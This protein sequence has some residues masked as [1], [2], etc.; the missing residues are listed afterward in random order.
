MGATSG[1]EDLYLP[2]ASTRLAL[3]GSSGSN[4][5]FPAVLSATKGL[6]GPF[7][8]GAAPSK[9]AGIILVPGFAAWLFAN[10]LH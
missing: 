5:F 7:R 8:S 1:A 6:T 3:I 2:P 9:S 4:N 10:I